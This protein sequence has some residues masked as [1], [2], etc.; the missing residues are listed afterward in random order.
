MQRRVTVDHLGRP[1]TLVTALASLQPQWNVGTWMVLY[2]VELPRRFP[3]D[4]PAWLVQP[5]TIVVANATSRPV[6]LV[7]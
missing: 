4:F 2:G 1:Q 5:A 7:K 6:V 3:A